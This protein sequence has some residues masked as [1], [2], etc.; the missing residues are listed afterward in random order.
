MDCSL[1]R[2]TPRLAIRDGFPLQLTYFVT[3]RCNLSCSHCFYTSA[4]HDP[5]EL[6]LQEVKEVVGTMGRFPILYY[7]GG[8]PFL[9]D[10]LAEITKAFYDANRIRYLSL[11]TNGT[12]SEATQSTVEEI[13]GACPKLKVVVNFSVNGL[14]EQHDRNCGMDGAYEKLITTY[15]SIKELKKKYSNLRVGFL[16]TYTSFNQEQM[17]QL[18]RELRGFQPDSISVNLVRGAPQDPRALD[19]N[20]KGFRD[21]TEEL[22]KDLESGVFPGHDPFLAALASYRVDAVYKTAC[23]KSFQTECYASRLAAVIYPNGDVYPCELLGADMKLGN[24]RD[25]GMDF[26][27]IWFSERNRRIAEWIVKSRCFCTHECNVAANTTFNL[28]HLIKIMGRVGA[29]QAKRLF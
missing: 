19:V 13:C 5:N 25:Y 1:L 12:L 20:L 14:N 23:E 9:R 7:S 11:P 4:N 15:G 18:Y 8:E 16:V 26:A 29:I 10:D 2:Y 21:V 17:G 24:L 28:R 27:R 3:N 22:K 6:T